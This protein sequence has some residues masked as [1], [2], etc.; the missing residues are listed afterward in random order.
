M[1]ALASNA[2]AEGWKESNTRSGSY[3]RVS[4]EFQGKRGGR[5]NLASYLAL[6]AERADAEL[7]A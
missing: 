4:F 7:A 2:H 5:A 6:S 3:H 1:S